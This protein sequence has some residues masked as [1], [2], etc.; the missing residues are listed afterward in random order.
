MAGLI[1]MLPR[2]CVSKI[3]SF[4]SPTDAYRSSM[5]S[6]MFH[7]AAES[8]VLWDMFLPTDYKDVVSRL[9]TPLTFTTKKELF[10]CLCNPILIDDGRK[11]GL[12]WYPNSPL[13][14]S[15]ALNIDTLV[16]FFFG[17]WGK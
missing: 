11:V 10:V 7:S 6:S 5:V 2:Y 4:T 16:F 3:L 13:N 14:I 1:D 9:I 17:E 15:H 12:K 8:D